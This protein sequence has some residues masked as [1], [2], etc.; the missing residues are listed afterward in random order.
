MVPDEFN[1]GSGVV[2]YWDLH[3]VDAQRCL[4][5]QLD[6]L[7]ED[8]VQV[9]YGS[10]TLLDVGWYPEFA[11]GGVFVITVVRD[12]NWDEPIFKREAAN[13]AEFR[14]AIEAGVRVA[15]GDCR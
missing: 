10:D 8:L 1:W 9:Q 4:D 11:D 7:K 5:E 14:S 2:A 15:N 6:E 12:G 13:V 3:G